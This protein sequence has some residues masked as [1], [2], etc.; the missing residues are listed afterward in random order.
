MGRNE[1]VLK[2]PQTYYV[3]LSQD[4]WDL[5][6]EMIEGA[7]I[8]SSSEIKIKKDRRR[9]SPTIFLIV[10]ILPVRIPVA[11]A[12]VPAVTGIPVPVV[13]IPVV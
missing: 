3:D 4:L 5:K 2:N 9:V 1:E 8:N 7:E 6:N 12:G 13:V 10:V 11:S